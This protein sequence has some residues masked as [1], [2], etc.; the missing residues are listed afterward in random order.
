[1][2]ESRKGLEF[3]KN[4]IRE[5]LLVDERDRLLSNL[6]SENLI[7]KRFLDFGV[8]SEVVILS[9]KERLSDGGLF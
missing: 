3:R 1:M 7:I 5:Y 8:K 6:Y 9:L 4:N 2:Y